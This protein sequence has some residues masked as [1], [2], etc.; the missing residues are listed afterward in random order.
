MGSLF[1]GF[2]LGF[3][4]ALQFGPM[5]LLLMRATLRAGWAVGLAVGAGIATIDGLYASVGALG[6][7]PALELE[8]VRIALGAAGA[9][10]LVVLGVRNLWS[11]LHVRLGGE[12]AADVATP[13]RAFRLA[14][15]GTASNPATIVS[16]S[17]IFAAAATAGAART[18]A[19]AALLVAGVALGSLTWVSLLA[20]GMAVAR[21]RIG[22]RA[23][24]A[25]DVLAGVGLIGFG[26]ALAYATADHR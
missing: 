9:V 1:A 5:S 11:A 14:L 17:A 2:G 3:F 10:L 16:W 4:V 8:P 22:T 26:G 6:A 24:R 23:Q 7:A 13:E 21:R 12:S 25:I 18:S 19:G 15:A 20:S